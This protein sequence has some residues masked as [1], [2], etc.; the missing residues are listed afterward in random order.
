MAPRYQLLHFTL[1]DLAAMIV[2]TDEGFIIRISETM[3]L[4][5]TAVNWDDRPVNWDDRAVNWH[6]VTCRY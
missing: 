1:I 4:A 2:H 5:D 3:V 6:A